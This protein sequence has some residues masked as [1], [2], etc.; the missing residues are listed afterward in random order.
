MAVC[1]PSRK[2]GDRFVPVPAA[3]R[4]RCVCKDR[5]PDFSGD[6]SALLSFWRA[7]SLRIL[8]LAVDVAVGV[9]V[10]ES[11]LDSVELG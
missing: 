10:A 9:A 11:E 3:I 8:E 1:L 7:A 6:S 4:S 2:S 5:D